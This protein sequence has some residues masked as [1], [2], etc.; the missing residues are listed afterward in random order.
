M[1]I[2]CGRSGMLGD[3]LAALP[4]A[5]YFRKKYP[6]AQIIWP[7]GKRFAQGAP[8]Y[9]NHPDIDTVFIFDGDEKPTSKRDWNMVK[10]C[11]IVIN[12]TPEHPDNRYPRERNIYLETFL[13]AGLTMDN[14][15]ELTEDEKI[16][17]LVKWWKEPEV[18]KGERKFIKTLAYW[19]QAGYGKENKRNSSLE[20][21]KKFLV[22]LVEYGPFLVHQFGSENDDRL[23][24]GWP[25]VQDCRKLSFFDQIKK[26]LECDIVIGTDSG[27]ALI[28]GAY[29]C[30]QISLLTDHWGNPNNPMALSTNNPN[31]TTFFGVGSADNISIDEVCKEVDKRTKHI[32]S[33]ICGGTDFL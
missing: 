33:Q 9:L 5:T 17:K 24:A 23:D 14:W 19:P 3:T 7:I 4:V 31:N 10:S 15:N 6:N 25:H 1:K 27:S 22:E 16:P 29:G 30:N 8:L 13:M 20:W 26:S 32:K 18:K 28:L 12:P 21:R 2:L 11:D